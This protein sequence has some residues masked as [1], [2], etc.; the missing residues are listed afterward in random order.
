MGEKGIRKTED[1]IRIDKDG[2]EIKRTQ[3]RKKSGKG[4]VDAK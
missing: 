4:N 3:G 1:R 2:E